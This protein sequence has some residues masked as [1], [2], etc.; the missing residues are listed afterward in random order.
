M[1]K[2]RKAYSL[3]FIWAL[4]T[5]NVQTLFWALEIQKGMATHSIILA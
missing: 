4:R 3:S 2:T 1:N 5:Y